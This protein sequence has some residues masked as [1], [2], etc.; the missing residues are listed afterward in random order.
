LFFW[1][2]SGAVFLSAPG[3]HSAKYCKTN[4]GAPGRAQ[5]RGAPISRHAKK[6]K[7]YRSVTFK[8]FD[9]NFKRFRAKKFY[10]LLK[11]NNDKFT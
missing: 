5:A 8:N 2:G 11:K 3:A 7:K 9:D 4:F 6:K 10:T 1:G